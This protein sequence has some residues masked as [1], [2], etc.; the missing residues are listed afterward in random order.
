MPT[1]TCPSCE[2]SFKV[3]AGGKA[4]CP[5]CGEWFVPEPAAPARG[6]KTG[7]K[8]AAGVPRAAVIGGAAGIGLLVVVLAVVFGTGRG[9][10]PAGGGG[11]DDPAGGGQAAAHTGPGA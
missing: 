1:V 10:P 7:R 8:P 2:K 3:P 4:R 5:E 6:G 9:K 11:G